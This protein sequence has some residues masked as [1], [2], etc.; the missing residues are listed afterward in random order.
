M[1]M[2]TRFFIKRFL[3]DKRGEL[4][5]ELIVLTAS[6]LLL[7]ATYFE[8]QRSKVDT[9][10]TTETEEVFVRKCGR[11]RTLTSTEDVTRQPSVN[12]D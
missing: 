2:K 11:I 3:S 5:V 10:V 8:T 7:G 12:C 1:K 4:P 6:I 9:G